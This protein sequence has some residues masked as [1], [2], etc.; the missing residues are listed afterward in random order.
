M[1]QI[2]SDIFLGWCRM[3]GISGRPHHYYVRQLWDWKHSAHV[4][5]LSPRLLATYCGWCG[6]TLAHAHARSGD[7]IQLAA[8]LGGGDVFDEAIADF[9]EAYASQSESDHA[10][11]TEAIDG[12]RIAVHLGV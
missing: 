8:Y 11:L 3:E 1:T 10:A 7:R 4:D 12:G 5:A 2:A 9:A 6:E